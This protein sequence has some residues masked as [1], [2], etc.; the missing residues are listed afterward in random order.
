MCQRLYVHITKKK[1]STNY[2]LYTE[3]PLFW[4][5]KKSSVFVI[6]IALL[7]QDTS[8]ATILLLGVTFSEKMEWQVPL[9]LEEHSQIAGNHPQYLLW[10]ACI[11]EAN[12]VLLENETT[13]Q[14]E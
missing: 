1:C 10:P 9:P 11:Q 4:K 12:S 2:L 7:L 3:I 5:G 8:D 13:C 14:C 6:H